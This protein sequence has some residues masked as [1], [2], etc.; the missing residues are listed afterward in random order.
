MSR[1]TWYAKVPVRKTRDWTDKE[2]VQILT[3]RK[4]G[5]GIQ[6]ISARFNTDRVRIYNQIRLMRKAAQHRCFKCG[7]PLSEEDLQL[8]KARRSRTRL[9]FACNECRKKFREYK[10]KNRK[11]ALRKG[12]CGS[13]W[14]KPVVPGRT[15]CRNCISST[16]RRRIMNG[17]C[18]ICGKRPLE[19]EVLCRPCADKMKK[20]R[21]AYA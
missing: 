3:L 2:R 15:M 4:Q 12:L 13:C 6:S 16:Y 1:P 19:T 10:I 14:D 11:K 21:L 5:E 20:K 9:I 17:L 8:K 18:G 7:K